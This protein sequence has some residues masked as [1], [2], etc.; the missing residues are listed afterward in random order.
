VTT[1]YEELERR[2]RRLAGHLRGL[3]V[4]LDVLVG[5]YV[6]RS[7]ELAVGV[8]GILMAGGA[9]VP[10][11]P[12]LPP[13][14]LT[15][16][17]GDTA[18]TL[19]VTQASLVE[20]LPPH[21]ARVVLV[22]ADH[23]EAAIEPVRT[24]P[25]DLGYVVYTS[26]STGRPK[27]VML[28]Q[29]ALVN[30]IEWHARTLLGGVPTLQ[31]AAVG[32]DVCFYEMFVAWRTGGV[33]HMIDE[34]TRRDPAALAEY[35]RIHA[36]AKVV[37]PVVVLQQLA[38]LF[39]DRP[40]VLRSL[41]E[42]TTTGEQM[43]LTGPVI[44][45]LRR[46]PGCAL[47]NHYGPSESHVVTAYTLP[48]APEAWVPHPP[49]GRPI[50]NTRVL[51]LG[52]AMN[53]CPIGVAGE[54]YIGGV[55]LARGYLG[56]PDLT[57]E[58][59]V[60]DPFAADPAA[61]LY[62]TGDIARYR[63]DGAIEYLGRRDDQVKIRGL[64][65]ELGEIEAAITRH[66]RVQET[67][68][69]V[70][71]DLPGERRLIAY[72]VATRTAEDDGELQAEL[73]A[74]LRESLPEVML[75]VIVELPALP[76]T[77]NGKI[78]KRALP[79]PVL[80]VAA[81]RAPMVAPRTAIEVELAAIWREVLRVD[82]IGVDDGFLELGGHSL[83][84]MQ[85]LTRVRLKLGVD[86]TYQRLFS[87]QSIARVAAWI[88]AELARARPVAPLAAT[89]RDVPLPLSLAQERLWFVHQLAPDSTAYACAYFF[90]VRG[91]LDVRAL[92]RA[93]NAIVARH[94]VFRTRF[95]ALD[96]RPVQIIADRGEIRLEHVDSRGRG[97]EALRR[98]VADEVARPFDLE[99]GPLLRAGE[100]R[101]ADD[102]RVCWLNVHH[103]IVDGWSMEVLLRELKL[104]Y[105]AFA[106]DAEPELPALPLQF[107]DHAVWERTTLA[108]PR[109]QEHVDWWRATLADAPAIL[110][111]PRD[112]PRPAVQ[113]FRGGTVA[114]RLDAARTGALTGLGKQLGLTVTTVL[115]AGYVALLHRYTG[116]SV[117]VV[118]VPIAGRDSVETEPMIGLFVNILP[119][120]VD[121]SGDP[122]FE[123][124]LRR[125]Q[126]ANLEAFDHDGVP[127][128]RIVQEL[129]PERA[130]SHNPV[131]QVSFAPQPRGER[132][133]QL[134]GLAVDRL[135]VD[136]R[137]TIFDLTLYMWEEEAGIEVALEYSADLFD[138]VSVERMRGHLE[139]LL[140]GAVAEPRRPLSRIPLMTE[141][142][143]AEAVRA[144]DGG[145][146]RSDDVI[147]HAE[148]ERHVARA[149]G[150]PA[151]LAG[152]V[153][154]SYSELDRRANQV[155][156]YL[157][158]CGVGVG[159]LVA[160]S[161]GRS[162][163]LIV[164]VLG[165][166]KAG[167]AFLPI[168]PEYPA[169]RRDF[170]LADSGAAVVLTQARL[171]A[172]FPGEAR[173]VRLDGE[174]PDISRCCSQAPAIGAP[175]G[176]YVIY[177]SGST[178]RPKG[179]LIDHRGAVNLA[180]AHRT[181]FD[182][183][184]V[185]VVLQFAALSFDAFVWELL[186][187]WSAGAALCMLPPD[188]PV[189]SRE[190][191][192]L[193][194]D[195]RVSLFLLPPSL[196]AV[197]PATS[198]PDLTHVLAGGEACSA[199]VV[200][201][202]G[203]GR[204]FINAYGPTEA[205]V[206][207]TYA[208]AT[209]GGGAP[210]IGGPLPG[211]R[212]YVL[213]SH[214]EPVP[215]G[216]PGELY[217]GGAG[218][219]RG[220]L[221]RPELTA[222]RFVED[223]FAGEPGARMYRTGDRVRR[224]GDGP[225][226]YLGRLDDQVKL[227]GFRVEL[228]EVESALRAH[229]RVQEAVAVAQPDLVAYV[230]ANAGEMP[231]DGRSEQI[232]AWRTLYDDTY[233]RSS[234]DGPTF[235]ITGWASSFTGLPIAAEVMRA[236]RDHTV[237]RL[238]ALRADSVWEIGS[239]TGL[240][241][242]PLAGRCGRYHG[243]DL[244]ARAVADLQR[245][246][247][248]LGMDHV[249]LEQR[250]ADDTRG[251][252][253][254]AF[255]LVICNSVVQ[256]F[257]DAA[258]L[259]EVIA[260]AVARVVDG[261]VVFIGDVRSLPLL[262]AFHAAIQ[263]TQA[264]A[265]TPAELVR[266][267]ALRAARDENEL[268]LGPRLFAAAAART[269]RVSH[270]E[271]WLKRGDS[272]DEMTR[273][274]YDALLFVGDPPPSLVVERTWLW[275][276][277][278]SSLD[279]LARALT[280]ADVAVVEVQGVPNAR[281]AAD[282]AAL[283][284]LR[285]DATAAEVAADA[286][287]A[288]AGA[289]EPEALWQLGQRL[290]YSV[291]VT[292]ASSGDLAAVDV[293]F[294]RG[295]DGRVR[296]W[297]GA[298]PVASGE[299]AAH[300]N[301][302]LR[303][304][305]QR[306][307]APAL[308]SFVQGRLPAY[309]V[310]AAIVIVEALPTLPNGKVDRRALTAES[311]D[312]A[313][314][315]HGYVHPRSEVE[316]A[317]A[318]IWRGVLGLSRVGIDDPFFELGGHSLLLAQ[319]R[320]AIAVRLGRELT[321]VEL[322]QCPTIRALAEH[323]VAAAPTPEAPPVAPAAAHASPPAD[324]IAV[325]GMAGR[326]PGAASV[327]ALWAALLAGA[328]GITVST[329]DELAA[330]GVDPAL[331]AS[332]RFVPAYGLIDD[333]YCFDAAFF[334]YSGHEARLMDPQQR[335]FLEAAFAALEDGGCDPRRTDG[336]IGVFA[337]SDAPRYWLQHVGVQAGLRDLEDMQASV[338][339]VADNLTSRVTFKLGLRGPAV[340]VLAACATSLVAVHMACQSL[341]AG[342]CDAALAGGV[343]IAPPSQ[344][345][346]LYE[347]GGILAADGHCRPFDAA[348]DG[349]VGANGVGVVAL[350]RLSDAIADGDA[351]RAVIRGSAIGNDG[352]DQ[353]GF[354][355]PSLRGQA[356]TI[357]R[358]LAAAGVTPDSVTMIEAHGTATNLGDPIEVAALR[359]VFAGA[360]TRPATIAL[361]S[362]KSNLGHLGA[363]AGVT[364]LIKAVLS[365]ER[366]TVPATL[367][368]TADNPAL[369]LANSPFFVPRRTMPWLSDGRPRR[370][371]VSAF[372]VGGTN[373]H[374][375]LEEAPPPP[376]VS[377][378]PTRAWHMLVLS[379]R[380]EEALHASARRLADHLDA[381][382]ELALGDVAYTLQR[383]PALASARQVIVADDLPG[384][385]AAL[386]GQ[387]AARVITGTVG[388]R[389]PRPVFVFPGMGSQ[390]VGMGR[391]LYAS[392]PVFRAAFDEC[393]A[394]LTAPLGEDI[395]DVVFAA[396]DDAAAAERLA[397]LSR[398]M[399][400]VFA[401]EVA[402]GRLL[403]A[404]GLVPAAVVGHS[405]GEYAAAELAGVMT[406]ADAAALVAAR[407]LLCDEMPAATLLS[408]PLSEAALA[409]WL[410]PGLSIAAI[411]SVDACVV[412]GARADV[413]EL[414][415]VL[416]AAGVETRPV[417]VHR[418]AH[419]S[420]VEP[421]VPRFVERVRAVQLRAPGLPIV[422]SMLGTWLGAEATRPEYWG[423]HLRQPVRFAAAVATLL[424]DPEH[425]LL[426]VGPGSQLT[427]LMRRQ[428]GAG[429]VIVTTM[430]HP[431]AR[432]AEP[433][434]LLAAVG[435]LWCAG[436]D[437][438]VERITGGEHRRHLS[439]PTYPFAR[440]QHL[441]ERTGHG[442]AAAPRR[443]RPASGS[444]AADPLERALADIWSEALGVA[445]TDPDHNFFDLGGTSLIAIQLRNQ[446][447]ERL[448]VSLPVHAL[449]EAPTLGGLLAA[450]RL[451]A[452]ERREDA[453][454][455]RLRVT[456]RRGEGTALFLVQPIGGT[457]YTYLSL[458]GRLDWPG[459]IYGLRASGMDPGEPILGD[460]EAIAAAYLA[461][462]RAV[463][464]AGRIVLGGH[465]AGGVIAYEMTR[466]LERQ[467]ERPALVMIDSGSLSP[468]QRRPITNTDD[469]LREFAAFESSAPAAHQALAAALSGDSS[470][471]AIMLATSRALRSY[472]PPPI[473]SDLLY[474]TA[475]EQLD[476]DD[477]E[478][479]T[480]WLARAR[481]GLSLHRSPG[482]HFT[483]MEEPRVDAL[484]RLLDLHLRRGS[485]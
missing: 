380:T 264:P 182:L 290:G 218:V 245:Q 267:R 458:V 1:S 84:A 295:G 217:V 149:P 239:G 299:A 234:A 204:R 223:P 226:E 21:A 341:R 228:G 396:E 388:A 146:S 186:I 437:I 479:W 370:A 273:F 403:V 242:L 422:S 71:E 302:P 162:L 167:A 174:W 301:E 102:E 196:L 270:L 114:A 87:E 24:V 406:L 402:L 113:S 52:E 332:P 229:P 108:E 128:D 443:S 268:V 89:A 378:E 470:L 293:L 480:Y 121:V 349:T 260:G 222:E 40:A 475:S 399:A 283:A 11:D 249:T 471:G 123:E 482:D 392:E 307:L 215:T 398:G 363:A 401:V 337:G 141:A 74:S 389:S 225:L 72:V 8:L 210:P 236:W 397:L 124:L 291:R 472:E 126:R 137:K 483:M 368:H 90:R 42:I 467:G 60:R 127:F 469:L 67:V 376:A 450:L 206:C 393:A 258:Y 304:R 255:D 185:R 3:G 327:E 425:A 447:R 357:G 19:L 356:D 281:V 237:E 339:N 216:V 411:N 43:H 348:A 311:R 50:D 468:A 430:A 99:R 159:A 346:Y 319:V 460:I 138:R 190:F 188:L 58:R 213:D 429:R 377:R 352:S 436:V 384:A 51:V 35:I 193:L 342:E 120:R 414:A 44:A 266:A 400:A 26:G 457:I 336:R 22:D 272:G 263:R 428:G 18:A 131:V 421:I 133:L 315:M 134:A 150:A 434:A 140:A 98:V 432:R 201:R 16:I 78:D 86:V 308:R 117:I 17:L 297:A 340:T 6:E 386:R 30:V 438:D 419:S 382:P 220:Y 318:D 232:D 47:H 80:A 92:E 198:L 143:R 463:C 367:H 250:L 284:R 328:E 415:A 333:A 57:A 64:R 158:E 345:G 23:A 179:V 41:R 320:A 187:A 459:P 79:A 212:V 350:K 177:T 412:A 454:A 465:S 168:D 253:E 31:Y 360:A 93:F 426:E 192:A 383:R 243:T 207:C 28:P 34:A 372:G 231:G 238:A 323:L 164:A 155:A 334:G 354:T 435:R 68:V 381:R 409:R 314:R 375:V 252:A 219:A 274:R 96:G 4:G 163:D 390:Y 153:T 321:M 313:A 379:A 325:I 277:V 10:L 181:M 329:P 353:I 136:A 413:A 278:E 282:V 407:G 205:T 330:A 303:A 157:R 161:V 9:Y 404:W 275:G 391:E 233:A 88:A 178:G 29:A 183:A 449:V 180:R 156:N 322:F 366:R 91:A 298:R 477:P 70:R 476:L 144:G 209:P 335:V 394:L 95:T 440:V 452:A 424:A 97:A 451:R 211:V 103:I 448:G 387:H 118:G 45:L 85:I 427:G 208:V 361:G 439:L 473:T 122:D 151:V 262:E 485:G 12:T 462:V 145:E 369:E 160:I 276:Q 271:I 338:A 101:L 116:E 36:I 385:S 142:E 199:E 105:E 374:V 287:A 109:L 132:D 165:V 148:F 111:V 25:S 56:R 331:V 107:A 431:R 256:Y 254:R 300:A 170:M 175:Q 49:I 433:E 364:G 305:Q 244:S 37:L 15:W 261:G 444:A 251:L 202:W 230:V 2:A 48:E 130:L 135:E 416:A 104:A 279:G 62:R 247:A 241:L 461:E 125:V 466:Q 227:R 358:A 147:M 285:G 286:E 203:H 73:A 420:F 94:E 7:L 38:V 75:P 484:A 173:V 66:P 464:P 317:L 221:G 69:V 418:A 33:I 115:L 359:R 129:Q 246:V 83:A 77:A 55:C 442:E 456:L 154:T 324:A 191:S 27:G 269:G 288:T 63:S 235:N 224:R 316:H 395:R 200:Q 248:A 61:R 214:G 152:G 14:R 46:L 410:T 355:A 351:I 13:A 310:P 171:A 172:R 20:S 446:V 139:A 5:L 417:A 197:Q 296:A 112:R 455:A 100:I 371:G 292:Y 309:M 481:G 344:R 445:A 189:P 405:L 54:I 408:V 294:E 65:I 343:A 82:P 347:E 289:V 76:L 106:R 373:A 166:L 81:G 453:A 312:E 306:Q 259:E 441:V 59:F 474:I 184:S 53:P 423:R 195:Q 32:F 280:A 478:P 257:P 194:R 326:F 176:A 362:L 240:L 39:E 365:L 169:E 265:D 110:D 119:I